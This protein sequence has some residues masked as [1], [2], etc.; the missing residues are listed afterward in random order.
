[1][2]TSLEYLEKGIILYGVILLDLL[3]STLYNLF[4]VARLRKELKELK[5]NGIKRRI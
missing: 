1:M 2:I 3:I 5:N 4:E